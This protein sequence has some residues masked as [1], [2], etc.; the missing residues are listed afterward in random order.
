[1]V[2]GTGTR[3]YNRTPEARAERKRREEKLRQ[4]KFE[5][6]VKFGE[7]IVGPMCWCGAFPFPHEALAHERC[8]TSREAGA[9]HEWLKA[10]KPSYLWDGWAGLGTQI[11]FRRANANAATAGR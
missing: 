7:C 5:C 11:K 3:S 1:M 6:P 2:Y 8:L 9:L 4:H 10:N